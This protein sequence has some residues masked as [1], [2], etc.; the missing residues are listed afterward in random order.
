[1]TSTSSTLRETPLPDDATSPRPVM[2]S[3][4]DE[5]PVPDQHEPESALDPHSIID[6]T[7]ADMEQARLKADQFICQFAE[8]YVTAAGRLREAAVQ[9]YRQRLESV[10]AQI[11]AKVCDVLAKDDIFCCNMEFGSGHMSSGGMSFSYKVDSDEAFNALSHHAWKD[12]EFTIA[13]FSACRYPRIQ[14]SHFH[15]SSPSLPEDQSGFSAEGP[16]G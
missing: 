5:G 16:R 8:A 12:R 2:A 3:P 13:G 6:E 15:F 14:T 4:V 7:R 9:R 11:A 10:P 1:M